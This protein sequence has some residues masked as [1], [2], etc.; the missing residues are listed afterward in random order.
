M[1][2]FTDKELRRWRKR[3]NAQK[4][5][6]IEEIRTSEEVFYVPNRERNTAV[7]NA[8][9]DAFTQPNKTEQQRVIDSGRY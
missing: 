9:C 4:L 8:I 3:T 1:V 6:R 5:A 2:Q 7:M